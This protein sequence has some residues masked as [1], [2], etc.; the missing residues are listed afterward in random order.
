MYRKLVELLISIAIIKL[1]QQSELR[2]H[3][4]GFDYSEKVSCRVCKILK[5]VTYT[6][7]CSGRRS[8]EFS[9]LSDEAF[10]WT[11]TSPAAVAVLGA[12]FLHRLAE[13][14]SLFGVRISWKML[15]GRDQI[16]PGTVNNWPMHDKV[17]EAM[18]YP[19]PS[20]N[21]HWSHTRIWDQFPI[22]LCQSSARPSWTDWHWCLH[23]QGKVFALV[24]AIICLEQ[25]HSHCSP[26]TFLFSSSNQ[27]C[28]W[29]VQTAVITRAGKA[30][31]N[32]RINFL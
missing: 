12:G 16:P 1:R 3:F 2:N 18:N 25:M 17:R 10:S 29:E 5:E 20:R 19:C 15:V 11:F 30:Q 14:V 6:D 9:L 8:T 26:S 21:Q 32:Q 23:I 24:H 22:P 31:R 28:I 27:H 4:W 13:T 7:L